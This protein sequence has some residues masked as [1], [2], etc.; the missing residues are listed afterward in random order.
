MKSTANQRVTTIALLTCLSLLTVF[1]VDGCKKDDGPT[2]PYDTPSYPSMAGH[3]IGSGSYFDGGWNKRLNIDWTVDFAAR[4]E[5]TFAGNRTGF[6]TTIGAGLGS[7]LIWGS[8]GTVTMSRQVTITDTSGV[9]ISAAGL[10]SPVG[11][12][13]ATWGPCTLSANGDTL[14]YSGPSPEN[15]VFTLVRQH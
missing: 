14:R 8:K 13:P 6:N 11:G 15:E 4:T 2:G 5:N 1:I 7:K 10:T 9:Y 12:L 3:W